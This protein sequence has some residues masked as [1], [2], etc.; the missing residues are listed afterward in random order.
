MSVSVARWSGTANC[1]PAGLRVDGVLT[2]NPFGHA[3]YLHARLGKRH[4]RLMDLRESEGRLGET[5]VQV[6]SHVEPLDVG[7]I[8]PGIAATQFR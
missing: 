1:A 5:R 3:S 7:D 6:V 8:H 2:K 4:P